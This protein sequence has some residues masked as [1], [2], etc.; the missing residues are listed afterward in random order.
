M[1]RERSL[2]DAIGG[3]EPFCRNFDGKERD[4]D[5]L[6][7]VL[8]RLEAEG[9]GLGHFNVSDL[10]F[11]KAVVAAAAQVG[12]PVLVV[13]SACCCPRPTYTAVDGHRGSARRAVCFLHPTPFTPSHSTRI[14]SVFAGLRHLH[15][16]EGRPQP[17]LRGLRESSGLAHRLSSARAAQDQ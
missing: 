9:V 15:P 6:R 16:F 3:T 1:S 4:M 11:V 12:V 2:V 17:F 7:S 10:V 8:T 5:G 13:L 14:Y